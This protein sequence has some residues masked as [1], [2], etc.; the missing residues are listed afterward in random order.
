MTSPG[1]L[2]DLV[3]AQLYSL[4]QDAANRLVPAL[5]APTPDPSAAGTILAGRLLVP[6]DTLPDRKSVV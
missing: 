4:A 2:W 1:E 3:R 6:L 5:P